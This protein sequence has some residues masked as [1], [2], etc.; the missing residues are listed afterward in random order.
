MS[1]D[2]GT[3]DRIAAALRAH[4][5]AV[6]LGPVALEQRLQD[7]RERGSRARRRRW[8]AVT[9]AGL[10]AAAATVL[11]VLL[12]AGGLPWQQEAA[13]YADREVAVLGEPFAFGEGTPVPGTRYSVREAPVPF[14]YSVPDK[15]SVPGTWHW[16]SGDPYSINLD[17]S[18]ST[19]FAGVALS[20]ETQVY[21][22][23]RP[24]TEQ[25]QLVPAPP[26]ADGW[27]AW[28]EATGL[29]EVVERAEIDVGGI[30]ATRLT[31]QV[32]DELPA[33]HV[34]CAPSE[35]CVAFRP[36]GPGTVGS[37]F[38]AGLPEGAT[39]ELTVLR[40]GDRT[41][42]ATTVGARDTADQWL[43][44]MRAVIDSFRFA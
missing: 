16:G 24:W 13:P 42:L 15:G 17:A 11:S 8:V 41:L 14:T 43:P 25:D 5:D 35:R 10:V 28:L 12:L 23:D 1:I 2:Q 39:G 37:G 26:D 27:Q 22:P 40:V 32:A 18:P 21:S 34:G 31:V 44:L 20:E 3:E 29:V 38:Q 33:A 7:V 6:T 9:G 4:A 30:P 19:G 36:L